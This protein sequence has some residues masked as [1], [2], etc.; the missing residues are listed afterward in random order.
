M[1]AKRMKAELL[2][3]L[4]RVR[5]DKDIPDSQATAFA[6]CDAIVTLA[7]EVE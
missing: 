6:A 7:A 2:A 5:A 1:T 4:R 3:S